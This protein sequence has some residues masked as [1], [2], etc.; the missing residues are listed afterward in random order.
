MARGG[1]VGQD[2][3]LYPAVLL[4]TTPVPTGRQEP[5]CLRALSLTNVFHAAPSV[6][7]AS[8]E[9][10][11]AGAAVPVW[12]PCGIPSTPLLVMLSFSPVSGN[13][14]QG[15]GSFQDR[16]IEDSESQVSVWIG[17]LESQPK[18]GGVC[19]LR[20]T[21]RTIA[22]VKVMKSVLGDS[23]SPRKELL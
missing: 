20:A 2:C 4:A 22:P 11:S 12:S 16:G 6:V 14:S 5:S 19:L 15:S 8:Y 18:P 21:R 9:R 3:E 1:S 17:H 13:Q 10:S 23:C 7:F